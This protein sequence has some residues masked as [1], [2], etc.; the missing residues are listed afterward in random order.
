MTITAL[1]DA[2]S[3]AKQEYQNRLTDPEK[4]KP[5]KTGLPEIDDVMN[6]GIT[7]E[8]ILLSL[9]ATAKTGKTSWLVALTKT[10]AEQRDE[11]VM[12]VSREESSFAIATRY[13][14]AGVSQLQSHIERSK[15]STLELDEKD[16]QK[17]DATIEYA[18]GNWDILLADS[19]RHIDAIAS[20]AIEKG[21][22]IVALDYFQLFTAGKET[23]QD[24]VVMRELLDRMVFH[25]KNSG[26]T[27]IFP[28]QGST[29]TS[30]DMNAKYTRSL[31]DY[32]DYVF[33]LSQH[34]I[35]DEP[36]RG[37]LEIR[38]MFSRHSGTSTSPALVYLDGKTGRLMPEPP[39]IT[40]D[41]SF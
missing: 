4:W 2:M 1:S 36:V 27:F 32:A 15:F 31:P 41:I 10:I 16:F 11:K 37:T 22:K 7:R 3:K 17:M 25:K 40:D 21:V 9:V 39:E 38:L 12:Y 6:G 29:G 23:D 28:A 13:M 20:A 26:L 24:W 30:N 35:G 14:A 33:H 19:V 5:T 18:K 34:K 8:P